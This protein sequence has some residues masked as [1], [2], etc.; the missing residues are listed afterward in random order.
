VATCLDKAAW[1]SAPIAKAPEA[2]RSQDVLWVL[3][4]GS[5]P[6]WDWWN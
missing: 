6:N 4:L 2:P 1:H 3:G 5:I